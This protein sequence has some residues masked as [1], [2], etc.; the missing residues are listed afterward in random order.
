MRRRA[1]SVVSLNVLAW[2]TLFAVSLPAKTR[3]TDEYLNIPS[4]EIEQTSK[5]TA[6]RADRAKDNAVRMLDRVT[7]TSRAKS[8]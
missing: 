2:S 7:I 6:N 3:I 1:A 5:E 4:L 8:N